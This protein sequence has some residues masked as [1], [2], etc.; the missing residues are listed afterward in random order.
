MNPQEIDKVL[1]VFD[2][3]ADTETALAELYETCGKFWEA[4]AKFWLGLATDERRHNEYIK[5]MRRI[6][7]ATPEQ[8]SQEKPFQPIALQTMIYTIKTLMQKVSSNQITREEIFEVTRDIEK[9][10]IESKYESILQ[11]NNSQY[12]AIV[13][14][15]VI[16]T[17]THKEMIEDKIRESQKRIVL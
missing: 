6:I 7:A 16:D 2:L 15:I 17:L 11:S 9:S 1:Q 13:K 4:D 8:F 3:L 5:S 12:N 14:Q 10:V